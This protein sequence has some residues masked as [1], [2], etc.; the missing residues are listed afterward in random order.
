MWG[1][2]WNTQTGAGINSFITDFIAEMM[3]LANTNILKDEKCMGM[4]NKY[5]NF[6]LLTS[7]LKKW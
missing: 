7:S 1:L 6:I 3:V 5:I 2:E 4:K